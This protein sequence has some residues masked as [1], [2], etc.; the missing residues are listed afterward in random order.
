MEQ[1]MRLFNDATG[2][3]VTG[4][5]PRWNEERGEGKVTVNGRRVSYYE[6]TNGSE[7]Y[8]HLEYGIVFIPDTSKKG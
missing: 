4:L 3:E 1:S 8:D 5:N 6:A 2:Y 7:T